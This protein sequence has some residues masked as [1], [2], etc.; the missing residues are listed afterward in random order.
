VR[1]R[2]A[3]TRLAA[4]IGGRSGRRGSEQFGDSRQAHPP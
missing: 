1:M 2:L 4:I 3:P